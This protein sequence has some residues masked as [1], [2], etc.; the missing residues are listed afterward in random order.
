[1]VVLFLI[2]WKAFILFCIEAAPI[3]IPTSSAPGYLFSTSF[4]TLVISC[5]FDNSHSNKYEVTIFLI[6]IFIMANH[7]GHHTCTYLP[8]LY[9]V[10]WSVCSN[11]QFK[12]IVLFAFLSFEI[13][14]IFW[15]YI[16][17]AS[18]L[19]DVF[20][21]NI[22]SQNVVCLFVLLIVSFT[23]KFIILIYPI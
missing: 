10:W 11:L 16:L 2:F 7:V 3:Y 12:K 17:D 5:L 8:F 18:P 14:L 4:P 1:M 13:F 20:S 21:A 22:L 23:E 9:L 19:S 15:T 6:C